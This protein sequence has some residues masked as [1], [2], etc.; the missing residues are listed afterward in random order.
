MRKTYDE[1]LEL[2]VHNSNIGGNPFTYN[3][4]SANDYNKFLHLAYRL[5]TDDAFLNRSEYYT[6]LERH[7]DLVKN[8]SFLVNEL[9]IVPGISAVYGNEQDIRYVSHGKSSLHG[10][11][12]DE[13]AVFDLA[14]VTKL[15]TSISYMQLVDQKYC[16]LSDPVGK[17]TDRFPYLKNITLEELLTFQVNLRTDDRI[18][19]KTDYDYAMKLLTQ[20]KN[21]PLTDDGRLYSDMPAIILGYLFYNICGLSLG[22]YIRDNILSECHMESSFFYKPPSLLLSRIID[23]GIEYRLI[24]GELTAKKT[25]LGEVHDEKAAVLINDENMLTGHAGLFSSAVDMSRFA[26]KLLGRELISDELLQLIGMNKTGHKLHAGG[27]SQFLGYLC[28]SKHCDRRLSEV[29][30]GAAGNAFAMSGYTGT[31]LCVDP[32]NNIFCFIGTNRIANKMTQYPKELEYNN[33]IQ[34]KNK[35]FTCTKNYVYIRDG[36]IRDVCMKLALQWKIY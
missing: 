27:Y 9:K 21:Y 7:S 15:F 6:A 13:N 20:I 34:Y 36:L 30:H 12:L 24:N 26:Q 4:F 33:Q 2:L 10:F 5:R 17:F 23:Y 31:Y 11:T 1:L 18:S 8:I 32:V 35:T 16:L 22:K 28:N 3:I 29:F 14:S 25:P 19:Y